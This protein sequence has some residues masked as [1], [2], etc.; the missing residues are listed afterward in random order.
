MKYFDD[1]IDLCCVKYQKHAF[2]DFFHIKFDVQ[3]RKGSKK[4]FDDSSTTTIYQ[5][6]GKMYNIPKYV[7]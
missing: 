4:F 6:V 2:F 1:G 5:N 7:L 3:Q